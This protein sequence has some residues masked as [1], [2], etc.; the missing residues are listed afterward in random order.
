MLAISTLIQFDSQL[1]AV[2]HSEFATFT[3]TSLSTAL[4]DAELLGT[5]T[6]FGFAHSQ[7]WFCLR[8]QPAFRLEG[9]R[10]FDLP[11]HCPNPDSPTPLGVSDSHTPI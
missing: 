9:A 10:V 7:E 4:P 5:V 8:H 11:F 3:I 2:T 6:P 1:R